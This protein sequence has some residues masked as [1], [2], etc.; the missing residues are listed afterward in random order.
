M[1]D[2]R[3]A[4]MELLH[5]RDANLEVLLVGPEPSWHEDEGVVDPLASSSA[6][7]ARL[8]SWGISSRGPYTP[9]TRGHA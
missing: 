7:R 6:R 4:R 8:M 9:G 3:D 1:L 5:V 2:D